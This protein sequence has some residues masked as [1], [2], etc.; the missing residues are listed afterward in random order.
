[1][2]THAGTN[3]LAALFHKDLKNR[4]SEAPLA[5]K[6]GSNTTTPHPNSTNAGTDPSRARVVRS[7]RKNGPPSIILVLVNSP[8]KIM[9]ETAVGS[10][11]STLRTR[12]T[13]AGK[14]S[15]ADFAR[16]N[17]QKRAKNRSFLQNLRLKVRYLVSDVPKS[18]EYRASLE[19]RIAALSKTSFRTHF[20]YRML[21]NGHFSDSGP[22]RAPRGQK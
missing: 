5:S 4:V 21:D 22:F 8:S 17:G 20:R 10:H 6:T 14:F 18:A 11:S 13:A 15:P 1:M 12:Q 19:R 3:E 7:R 9:N 2:G 16:K